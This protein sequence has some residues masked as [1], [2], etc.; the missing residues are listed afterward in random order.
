MIEEKNN[1]PCSVSRTPDYII[2]LNAQRY[3]KTFCVHDVKVCAVGKIINSTDC[4]PRRLDEGE[5]LN[6]CGSPPEKQPCYSLRIRSWLGLR[7]LRDF[8]EKA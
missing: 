7:D 4:Q 6:S 1:C 2:K 8:P 3:G 5:S